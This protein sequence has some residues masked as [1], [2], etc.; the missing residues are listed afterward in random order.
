MYHY[1]SYCYNISLKSSKYQRQ[2]LYPTICLQPPTLSQDKT[3]TTTR[4]LHRNCANTSKTPLRS[5]YT[6]IAQQD[7]FFPPVVVVVALFT[8]FFARPLLSTIE[9]G[10]FAK[11]PRLIRVRTSVAAAVAL[12]GPRCSCPRSSSPSRSS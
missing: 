11:P 8:R 2:K 9:S 7:T 1:M 6:N 5:Q 10:F 3:R 12:Q 4:N